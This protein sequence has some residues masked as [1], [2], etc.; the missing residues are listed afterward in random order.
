MGLIT[1]S[2]V[3][4][5]GGASAGALSWPMKLQKKFKF[6]QCWFAGMLFGLFFLPWLVKGFN[7]IVASRIRGLIERDRH[8]V[9]LRTD[10]PQVQ[11]RKNCLLFLSGSKRTLL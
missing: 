8:G 4:G 10:T 3:A 5:L 1:G 2:I 9:L 6:E 11:I 7:M